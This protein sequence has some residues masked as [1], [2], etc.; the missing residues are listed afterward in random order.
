M[1]GKLL[2]DLTLLYIHIHTHLGI[3]CAPLRKSSG[4]G[5]RLKALDI[6]LPSDKVIV[7]DLSLVWIPAVFALLEFNRRN[8]IFPQK[9]FTT[10]L[11][12]VITADLLGADEF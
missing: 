5:S 12:Q 7:P 3:P 4:T 2:Q 9:N 6:Q 11:Y 10:L 1:V 8:Y